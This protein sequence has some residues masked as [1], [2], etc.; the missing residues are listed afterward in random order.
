MKNEKYK[1]YFGIIVICLLC[2]A[3]GVIYQ[4]ILDAGK[5]DNNY[6]NLQTYVSNIDKDGDGIDDQ[7][8]IL[9][10]VKAYIATNPQYKSKYYDTGYP[11]DN[12]GVCT[13]VV[14]YGLKN[15]G[16]DIKILLNEDVIANPDRYDI[17]KPDINIDFRRVRNLKEYFEAN[18][19]VLTTD[20]SNI[21][22]WQGGDIV[23]FPTHIGIVSNVRNYHGVPY[24]IHHANP[25][26]RRYE[27]NVLE[28]KYDI[29][30]HYRI[31]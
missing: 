11:N 27:E 13:D 29:I 31:S 19:I 17:D 28:R 9:N 24:L 2:I 23:V 8:D 25:L 14:C 30:G 22:E 16:Y 5:Y 15:A 20:L 12:Y 18:A 1:T 3:L 7:T 26:Q 4:I 21:E 10:N 6:F